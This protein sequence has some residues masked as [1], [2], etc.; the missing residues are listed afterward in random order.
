MD[1]KWPLL[2]LLLLG[3]LPA[4][5]ALMVRFLPDPEV[6]EGLPVAHASRLR[7]LPR[8]A[9]LARQQLLITQVQLVSV[10]LV[11]VGAVWLAARPMHTEIVDKPARGGDL[12]L[13]L[14]LTPGA[15][16]G[17]LAAL[18]GARDLL[19]LLKDQPIR[20]GVQGF[21]SATAELLALT[22]NIDQADAAMA[23]ASSVL[24]SATSDAGAPATGDALVTCAKAF[25]A[26][27]KKRGRAVVLVGTGEDSGSLLSIA[28]AS[29]IARDRD[30]A[31]YAVPVGTAVGKADFKAAAELTGGALISG[32]DP[33][34][35]IWS[36][37]S[38]RL[39]PPPTPVRRDGPLVPGI[40]TLLGVA[41]LLLA[42]LRGLFR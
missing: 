21:T 2:L 6:P 25:D 16:E 39:D 24:T 22:D 7:S 33:L 28:D 29:A 26:P 37:E 1:L 41:G 12:V 13:C 38:V 20:I 5:Y 10:V 8:Y 23:A 17:T 14:D 19:P 30:V 15:R 18:T 35:Q 36:K 3:I 11:L 4:A 34:D 9:E 27:K 32:A 40:L 42:G 31:I